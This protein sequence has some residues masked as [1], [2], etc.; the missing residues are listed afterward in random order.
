ML[1]APRHQIHIT[2]SLTN[3]LQTKLQLKIILTIIATTVVTV[4]VLPTYNTQEDQVTK[5]CRVSKISLLNHSLLTEEA[6]PTLSLSR[7]NKRKSFFVTPKRLKA[8]GP[9][10]SIIEGFS[11]SKRKSHDLLYHFKRTYH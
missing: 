2:H 3:Y 7:N 8:K 5:R 10:H 4:Q 9:A 11:H 6:H 1:I